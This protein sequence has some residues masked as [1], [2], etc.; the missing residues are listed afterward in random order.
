METVE[1]L[2]RVERGKLHRFSLCAVHYF[3]PMGA[4]AASLLEPVPPRAESP[5]NPKVEIAPIQSSASE[6]T[7]EKKS[8]APKQK[9]TPPVKSKRRI[10]SKW[11]DTD[12]KQLL[13]AISVYGNG[14]W[15]GM[16]VCVCVENT[17]ARV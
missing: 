17:C 2:L 10:R 8:K 12:V 14:K 3:V 4:V 16:C 15:T 11:S 5:P 9:E 6:K 7:D 1:D 13:Q